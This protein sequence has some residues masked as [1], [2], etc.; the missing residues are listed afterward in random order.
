MCPSADAYH[1]IAAPL[2]REARCWTSGATTTGRALKDAFCAYWRR[3]PPAC[4][5]DHI[6]PFGNDPLRDAPRLP[7]LTQQIAMRRAPVGG[8][9]RWKWVDAAQPVAYSFQMTEW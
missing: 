8:V 4:S 7:P 5:Y 6:S 3:G 1:R 9:R 2:Y